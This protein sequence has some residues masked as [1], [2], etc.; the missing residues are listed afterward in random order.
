MILG[1]AHMAVNV[2]DLMEAEER[3]KQEGYSRK[4]LFRGVPNHPS[5]ERYTRSYQP[6]HD[7]MLLSGEGLWPLELTYHGQVNFANTQL[8]WNK[9]AIEVVLQDPLP[10]RQFLVAALGFHEEGDV[11]VLNSRFPAWSCRLRVLAGDSQPVRLDAEGPTCLAFYCNRIAVDAETLIG[12]GAS[13]YTQEFDFKL[14][15]R[16]MLISLMRAPGGPL[17]ELIEPRKK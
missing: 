3:W 15:E 16:N 7:L 12:L 4:A 13:D 2:S 1:F 11:L 8:R 9:G 17:L 6:L 5:K 10:F 14:G